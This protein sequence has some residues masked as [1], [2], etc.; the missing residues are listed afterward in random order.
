MAGLCGVARR[1]RPREATSANGYLMFW[2]ILGSAGGFAIGVA[3]G[4]GAYRALTPIFAK[5]RI[6]EHGVERLGKY[7][8]GEK[9]G[10]GSMG[11]V[12]HA[13]HA[14]LRRPTVVKILHASHSTKQAVTRFEREVQFTSQ[15]NH[16]NTMAVFDYGRSDEGVFYYA[17]EYLDG[18][19]LHS[20]VKDYGPQPEQRVAHILK[21]VCG[22][23]YEAHQL[24]LVHR[25]I[26]ATNVM[27]CYRAEIP[28]FV[29]V[30]DFGLVKMF[31]GGTT[32]T[33]E[34]SLTGT[35]LYMSP[36]AISQS[37]KVGPASD[38]YA[39][40]VLGYFLL[41]GEYVFD[42]G[43]AVEICKQH[44]TATPVPPSSRTKAPISPQMDQAILRCLA[45]APGDRP[46]SAH[47]LAQMLAACPSASDWTEEASRRWWKEQ[48]IAIAS[49]S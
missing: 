24:G 40:G 49:V 1:V 46:A 22:S 35:P 26:K 20:L 5:M 13:Q 30:L 16:P 33:M 38:L 45:K 7:K 19:T 18:M 23:L 6:A 8:L 27:L 28:D 42:D 34:G 47:Q 11:A 4:I 41:T 15:L 31:D 43:L 9:I 37:D 25:D 17:M 12:Y 10:E 2:T 48:A 32:V 44:A 29:K 14:L 39:L 3:A 21:Q 36:E